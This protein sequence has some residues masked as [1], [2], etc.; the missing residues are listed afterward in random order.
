MTK[1]FTA[2]DVTLEGMTRKDRILQN[3][4]VG[5]FGTTAF[6]TIAIF[7]LTWVNGLT[8]DKATGSFE[9]TSVIAID[10]KIREVSVFINDEFIAESLPVTVRNLT[11]GKYEIEIKRKNFQTFK[12][13]LNL[14]LGQV[15]LIDE[16]VMVANKPLITALDGDYRMVDVD[17][18]GV[19][20]SLVDGKL[21][22]GVAFITR[23]HVSPDKIYRLNF[24]YLY[25]INNE[26]RLYIPESNQDFLIA[27]TSGQEVLI[28]IKAFSWSF[29]ILDGDDKSLINVTETSEGLA[30]QGQ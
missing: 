19:G 27:A 7:S 8:Y 1:H 11:S 29:A 4:M 20:L 24:T 21:Y 10:T 17:S 26:I 12:R 23:F 18:L 2:S 3:F 13:I 25:V 22:D 14:K 16:V 9:Q 5:L 30:D 15:S 6:V 28:N